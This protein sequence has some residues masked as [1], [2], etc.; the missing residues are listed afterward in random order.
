[1]EY[2]L[3]GWT[4]KL[5]KNPARLP[6]PSTTVARNDL[7]SYL[8]NEDS[9]YAIDVQINPT[10]S[11]SPAENSYINMHNHDTGLNATA[12]PGRP[13]ELIE[14]SKFGNHTSSMLHLYDV[15]RRT[16]RVDI[17]ENG[18]LGTT[19]L[20]MAVSSSTTASSLAK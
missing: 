8:E 10:G 9:D 6:L 12:K 2:D 1:M 17:R 19:W 18:G 16:A 4:S 15:L 11:D 14:T 5:Q 20:T 13:L 7:T 3:N